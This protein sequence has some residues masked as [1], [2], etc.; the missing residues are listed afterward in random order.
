ML[1]YQAKE[2]CGFSVIIK[3]RNINYILTNKL[4][5]QIYSNLL[6]LTLI[7]SFYSF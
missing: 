5:V 3:V 4:A 7:K 1:E 2:D 6:F